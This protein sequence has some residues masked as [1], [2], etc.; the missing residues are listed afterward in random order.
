MDQSQ[1]KCNVC[2][3]TFNSQQELNEHQRTAHGAGG[4]RQEGNRPGHE[5]QRKEDKIAS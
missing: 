2:N 3:K 5:P 1:N 4:S